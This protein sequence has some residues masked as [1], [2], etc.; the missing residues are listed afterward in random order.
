MNLNLI[1]CG[2]TFLV[3]PGFLNAFLMITNI[4]HKLKVKKQ[5]IFKKKKLI[6][7]YLFKFKIKIKYHKGLENLDKKRF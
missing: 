4:N 6:K 7:K 1:N 3:Q 2:C 5:I